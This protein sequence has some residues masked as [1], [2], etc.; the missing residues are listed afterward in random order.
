MNPIQGNPL[1]SRADFARSVVD[2]W[3]PLKPFFSEGRARVSLG[4]PAAH[5]TRTA[6][7]LEGFSRPLFGLAPLAAGGLPFDDWAM[8]RE[9]YANGTNPS[10]PEFWGTF[11]GRDQRLVESAAVGF[12]LLFAK[13][14]LW[15]PLDDASRGHI[16]DWLKF[17]LTQPTADNNWHFFHVLASLAL[18]H[19]GVE[20]DLSVREDALVRLEEFY[21]DDGW[22]SDG[23]ARRFDHYIGFAMHFYGLLYAGLA[24]QDTARA[25]RFRDRAAT[26]AQEF[27]HWFD[28]DGASLA[29][30]RS[31]TYRFAQASF[32]AG[33]AFAGVEAL[34]WGEIRGLWARNLR[35]WGRRDYF[36]RDG[37]MGIGYA[38]PSLH[39][40]EIYN[41][42]G[43]PYW[44]L[45]AYLP[46]ALPETHPFW[47]TPEAPK[48]DPDATYASKVPGMVGF[49]SG[50]GRVVLSSCNEMRVA[51]RGGPEKYAK[52]AYSTAFGFS[53]D[54]S[55]LGFAI[56]PF[57]NMLALSPDGRAFLTRSEL[58]DARIGPDWLY[59]RWV[60]AAGIEVETWLIARPPFHIRAHRVTTD[61][62]LFTTEGGFA[63]ERT[64][65]APTE[66]ST[67]Q[68]R[69]LVV[70]ADAAS[71]AVALGRDGRAAAIRRAH[72][73]SSL[74]FPQTHVPHLFGRIDSGTTWLMGAFV[75]S[76]RPSDAAL[77]GDGVPAA[78]AVAELAAM[79]TGGEAVTGMARRE[80]VPSPYTAL[81]GEPP[82][83]GWREED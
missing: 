46:L 2:L 33:L 53:M 14:E 68:G 39:M 50:A 4:L 57:D 15:D 82:A 69:A 8:F 47:A 25:Q 42:P 27:R 55:A 74:Y 58:E 20:H 5:F 18:S 35:W 60:P 61:R 67:A 64:D 1:S 76:T 28:A 36:D 70:T 12:G 6:A 49:G 16:A 52:F 43:S 75:A 62:P 3:R 59:S 73:N 80:A 40:C 71:L 41:S 79:R 13:N 34:P 11:E 81:A 9:G 63:I 19:V 10:H 77:W 83:A 56:N 32:W 37:V 78:P 51:L 44:A 31:M 48:A 29:F 26:F 72:P 45:K 65:A 22:Y 66:E 38:Y 21:V 54:A 23:N 30:G 17:T 7:E 24:P